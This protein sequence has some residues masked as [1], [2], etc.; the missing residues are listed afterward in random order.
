MRILQI[1]DHVGVSCGVMSVIMNWY[2]HIDR[3]K[4]QFDFLVSHRC[5]RS[6]EEE[7]L[8]LGGRVFYMSEDNCLRTKSLPTICRNVK[9]F[10][11]QHA[12]EYT[13]VHLHTTTFS[14]P[15]LYY[16]KRYGIPKRISHV[17]SISM[18]N[19]ALSSLR[20]RL[21]VLPL[22]STA[23]LF[24]ACSEQAGR[25]YYT[26]LKISSFQV[27]LNG[28][29][30]SRYRF[31]DTVREEVRCELKVPSD[32]FL[33]THVSNMT[34]LKNTP[35]VVDVFAQ[36]LQQKPHALLVLVGK[37]PLP[38]EVQQRIDSY[39]LAAHVLCL[40][41][42]SDVPSL[43]RASD[44]CLMPSRSEGLGLVAIECQLAGLPVIT[45]E[46]F[47][48][49]VFATPLAMRASFDLSVWTQK[50]METTKLPRN[51]DVRYRLLQAFD[52]QTVVAQLMQVYLNDR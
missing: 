10:M 31:S 34:S 36:I 25:R 14:Y 29:D 9:A 22:K 7:I 49:E 2:R 38:S 45:S 43:L 12:R 24:L 51:D 46:G 5:A 16:A 48:D 4:V 27:L 23:N 44:L 1:Y 50:A 19:T 42:R 30:F 3:Q 47:P 20:N 37:E 26:P 40:G 33:V 18:G 21:M 17:H 35:F 15:Y 39:D 6:Y 52:I 28:I 32:A 41:V 11:K 8:A 13:V